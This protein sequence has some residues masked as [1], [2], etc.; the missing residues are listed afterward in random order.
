MAFDRGSGGG[1]RVIPPERFERAFA[2]AQLPAPARRRMRVLMRHFAVERE[3]VAAAV[4]RR[5]LFGDTGTRGKVAKALNKLNQSNFVV[6][7]HSIFRLLVDDSAVPVEAVFG[8]IMKYAFACPGNSE[9]YARVCAD[10]AAFY[11]RLRAHIMGC[12]RAKHADL[13]G[14]ADCSAGGSYAAYLDDVARRREARGC[15]LFVAHLCL[16]RVVGAGLLLAEVGRIFAAVEA[17]V[18]AVRGGERDKCAVLEAYVDCLAT[19]LGADDIVRMLRRTA[20][21]AA[22]RSRMA[23]ALAPFGPGRKRDK[24]FQGKS[25]FG[26]MGLRGLV[27]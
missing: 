4:G 15:F 24:R 25:W 16:H 19:I 11:P 1:V 14:S 22:A 9:L 20:G 23:A 8:Q 10:L 7:S 17:A 27:V 5:S 21:W 26:L 18:E 6:V 2:S 12:V 3:R 13:A